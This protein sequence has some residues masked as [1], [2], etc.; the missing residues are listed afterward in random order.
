MYRSKKHWG[1]NANDKL[2]M[3]TIT[4]FLILGAANQTLA[5]ATIT[6]ISVLHT[7]H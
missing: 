2:K 5:Q 3:T 1:L 6:K 7:L 4:K